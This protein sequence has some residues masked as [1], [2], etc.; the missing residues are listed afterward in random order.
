MARSG[1]FASP[2]SLVD[3]DSI[4]NISGFSEAS[5]GD[6][7]VIVAAAAA[8][9]PVHRVGTPAAQQ[10]QPLNSNAAVA[11]FRPVTSTPVSLFSSLNSLPL[12]L[13]TN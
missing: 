4:S 8:G 1:S 7:S 10:P 11:S 6:N 3:Q 9:S 12:E 5:A 2:S 13:S